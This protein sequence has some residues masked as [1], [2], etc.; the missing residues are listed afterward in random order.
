[1]KVDNPPGPVS[2]YTW[3]CLKQSDG[4]LYSGITVTTCPDAVTMTLHQRCSFFAQKKKNKVLLNK[5]VTSVVF[6]GMDVT[7]D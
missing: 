7:S 3:N 1:M 4:V 2:V 6:I 5:S